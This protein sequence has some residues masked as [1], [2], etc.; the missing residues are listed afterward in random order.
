MRT[1]WKPLSA[2]L[3]WCND[4]KQ[5]LKHKIASN[6]LALLWWVNVATCI[7][8]LPW[9]QIFFQFYEYR[10]RGYWDMTYMSPCLRRN[11]FLFYTGDDWIDWM[12]TFKSL[13]MYTFKS[14]ALSKSWMAII[15]A[16]R[17]ITLHLMNIFLSFSCCCYSWRWLLWLISQK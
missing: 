6:I 4:H 11:N 9:W 17:L 1:F 10:N 13:R 5:P 2:V 16:L 15:L 3:T 8:Y 7:L 14:S 12:Y